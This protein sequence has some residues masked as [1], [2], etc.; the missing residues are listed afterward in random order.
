MT[1]GWVV[2]GAPILV[3]SHKQCTRQGRTL[4][5]F[6]VTRKP[7]Q[8]VGVTLAVIVSVKVGTRFLSAKIDLDA[9][10]DIFASKHPR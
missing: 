7:H 8:E 4:A 3:V 1:T 10:I 6:H 2:S 9:I 5:C